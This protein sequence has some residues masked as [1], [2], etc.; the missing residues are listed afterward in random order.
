MFA[1]NGIPTYVPHFHK[2]TREGGTIR[3]GAE[4]AYYYI[5]VA[6][7][8]RIAA[9]AALVRRVLP[10]R[11]VQPDSRPLANDPPCRPNTI[12]S[13]PKKLELS[14]LVLYPRAFAR[15]STRSRYPPAPAHNRRL[16]AQPLTL[17]RTR[18]ELKRRRRSPLATSHR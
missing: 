18:A 4:G 15:E 7:S 9:D 12:H 8:R 11:I 2:T 3:R 16:P 6:Q 14:L 1:G 17:T 10:T 13:H 5:L